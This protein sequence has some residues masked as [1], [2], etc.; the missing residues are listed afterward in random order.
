M[1]STKRSEILSESR[2]LPDPLAY[3]V[4][5]RVKVP[6]PKSSCGL[7]AVYDAIETVE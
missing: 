1:S 6:K 4:G 3:N 2:K 5:I 7:F